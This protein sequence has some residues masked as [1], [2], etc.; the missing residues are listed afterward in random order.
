MIE[1]CARYKDRAELKKAY[2]PFVQ[3]GALFVPHTDTLKIHTPV[4]VSLTLPEKTETITF[5]GKVI[6]LSP[7]S[8]TFNHPGIGIQFDQEYAERLRHQIE[9][10]VTGV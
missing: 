10:L 5:T 9:D 3:E 6:L 1:I 4:S 2:L 7:S 8:R